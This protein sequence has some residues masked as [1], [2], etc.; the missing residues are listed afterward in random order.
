MLKECCASGTLL[1][2]SILPHDMIDIGNEI[3]YEKNLVR[4]LCI[5]Y[6]ENT[7]RCRK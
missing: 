5:K 1:K 6:I 4:N 7:E 2:Q 3:K